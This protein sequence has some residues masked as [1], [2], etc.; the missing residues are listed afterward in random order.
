MRYI[1]RYIQGGGCLEVSQS[2]DA[3]IQQGG[4]GHRSIYIGSPTERGRR[5]LTR[6]QESE[7][8]RVI[9][10]EAQIPRLF[11]RAAG[12]LKKKETVHSMGR[13]SISQKSEELVVITRV[14]RRQ[15]SSQ[16]QEVQAQVHSSRLNG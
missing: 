4:G 11:P 16:N 9:S 3:T 2:Q 1:E 10:E 6:E 14:V 5:F 13:P 7:C 12:G 15:K 8:E